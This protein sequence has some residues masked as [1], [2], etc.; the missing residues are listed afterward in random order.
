MKWHHIFSAIVILAGCIII[1]TS[2]T[3]IKKGANLKLNG[4]GINHYEAYS[5]AK[6]FITPKLKSPSSASF[7]SYG[8]QSNHVTYMGN[9]E[10]RIN[11]YV[12]S[13]NSFGATIR[14]KFSCDIK[15]VGDKVQMHNL[16][17][18]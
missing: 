5:Y 11:S 2:G 16:V 7:A 13:Q 6:D 18:N 15:V 4:S 17:L 14:T 12:D 10:Y 8:E 9:N 3:E 1:A